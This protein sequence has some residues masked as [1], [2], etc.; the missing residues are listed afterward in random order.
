MVPAALLESVYMQ[1]C[2]LAQAENVEIG[3]AYTESTLGLDRPADAVGAST[4][5]NGETTAG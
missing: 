2:E 5:G 1:E 4:V 3:L